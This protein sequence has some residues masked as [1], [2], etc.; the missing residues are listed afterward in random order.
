M[1]SSLFFVTKV[2]I[3]GIIKRQ[4][5]MWC[6]CSE[7]VV[8][9]SD[10][11][12]CSWPRPAGAA[13]PPRRWSEAG[14]APGQRRREE[15]RTRLRREQVRRLEGGCSDAVGVICND[16]HTAYCHTWSLREQSLAMVVL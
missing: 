14:P 5:D 8:I 3:I 11:P 13:A 1:C 9:P 2:L 7:R 16:E 6:A 15:T 12:P 10:S 4:R